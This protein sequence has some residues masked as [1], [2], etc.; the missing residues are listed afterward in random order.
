MR[1]SRGWKY[2]CGVDDVKSECD[3]DDYNEWDIVIDND[4]AADT[5]EILR[6]ILSLIP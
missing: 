3:L 2:D 1:Q 5:N 4:N 6:K